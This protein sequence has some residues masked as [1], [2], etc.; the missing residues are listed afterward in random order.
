M[1][2]ESFP[3]VVVSTP[4]PSMIPP[5]RQAAMGRFLEALGFQQLW[6]P[7]HLLFA[8]GSPAYDPWTT[9]GALAVKTKRADFGPAVTDPHRTHPA[10]VAQRLA[11]LDQL[12]GG[13][14]VLGLGSGEAQNLEPFGFSWTERKVGKIK[15][16][17]TVV[18]GLL[19]SREPFT[20]R[21]DFFQLDRAR[22]SVRPF[23]DR[24]IPIYMAALGPMMQKVAGR[25]ADGWIP[26][27]IPSEAFAEYFQPMAE[28]AQAA[29]RDPQSLARVA[30]VALAIDT[31]G[32]ATKA[33]IIEF[34]RPLSGLLVWAPVMQRL[35]LSFDPPPEA[36]CTYLEVN[37][38][39]PESLERY[40]EM[41]RW[42]PVELMDKAFTFGDSE[43]AYRECCNFLEAGATHLQIAFCSPD[44]LGNFIRFAH[45]VL[46][47]LTGR[48]PTMLARVLGTALNTPIK[49][50][51]LRR[52]FPAPRTPLPGRGEVYREV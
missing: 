43:N 12:S 23:R 52:K 13:R 39:D 21:G 6:L 41:E 31:D 40:Y 24:R 18:R 11:T 10:V 7:D 36:Q 37:P 50:G 2:S 9:M 32:H 29:G 15:E 44:P 51:W 19:D 14:V 46:P 26:T 38:C 20:F 30:T 5:A 4:I 27:L 25:L 28:A 47:R 1:S 17:I 34:L 22:L 35:G 45:D 33:E 42:M 48:P 16:F 49:R 3:P 8:D